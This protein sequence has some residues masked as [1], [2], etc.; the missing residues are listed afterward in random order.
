MA[1]DQ[2]N[3]KQAE[4]VKLM[5]S[6]ANVFLTGGAGTGKSH[7]LQKFVESY[8]KGK[9]GLAVTGPTGVSAYA[10]KGRTLHSWA[11]IFRGEEGDFERLYRVFY[12]LSS[13]KKSV[14][15]KEKLWKTYTGKAIKRWQQ[16]KTLIIDEVSMLHPSL[17]ER[18]N[19]LACA[20][21]SDNSPFGGIQ[22]IVVGDFCQL[23]P[24]HGEGLFCFDSEIWGLCQFQVA[25]LTQIIRQKDET[26][27][28]LLQRARLGECNE[29]DVQWLESR[30]GLWNPN[31]TIGEIKPTVLYARNKEVDFMNNRELQK[32]IDKGGKHKEYEVRVEVARNNLLGMKPT[33]DLIRNVTKGIEKLRFAVGAQVM[34]TKNLE[35][36][37]GLVNGSRGV[38][39]GF[40]QEDNIIIKFVC[41]ITKTLGRKDFKYERKEG[42]REISLVILQI[43]LRLA[44]AVSIHKSQGATLDY[45]V[46]DLSDV[47]EYGQAYV[48]LSRVRNLENLYLKGID[49]SKINCHPSVKAFYNKID[50]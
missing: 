49:F 13:S 8:N 27:T 7:V 45:V 6:G 46:T 1:K 47:F 41:G 9:G 14:L 30:V 18:L 29:D 23:P 28:R 31:M 34:L 33:Q 35:V 12:S 39:K 25:N 48:A 19:H 40:D 37:S 4:A 2:L 15:E 32:L 43:P 38:V 22:L 5:Q 20:L 3:K 17:F 50:G 42:N 44:W 11:G 26:F 21:R 16:V 36:D 24:V 10:V